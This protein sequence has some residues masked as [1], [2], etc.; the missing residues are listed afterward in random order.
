[1][2]E[3]TPTTGDVRERFIDGA[4][5]TG[6]A[7][8]RNK[9]RRGFDRWL[10]EVKAEAWDEGYKNGYRDRRLEAS[11]EPGTNPYRKEADRG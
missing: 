9:A 4:M 3:Y 8:S 10:A 6:F 7:H 1:M 5:V 2:A 11:Y